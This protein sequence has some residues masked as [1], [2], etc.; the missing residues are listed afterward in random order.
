MLPLE[1]RVLANLRDIGGTR[2]EGGGVAAA[3]TKIQA[4]FRGHQVREQVRCQFSTLFSTH[5]TSVL[6]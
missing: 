3:A 6:R 2:S 5:L 4:A 1:E